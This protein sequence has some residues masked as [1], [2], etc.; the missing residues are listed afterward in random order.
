VRTSN[1]TFYKTVFSK[2]QG[3]RALEKH[4]SRWEGIIKTD[5]RDRV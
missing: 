5:I 3:K 1:F 2:L 4:I